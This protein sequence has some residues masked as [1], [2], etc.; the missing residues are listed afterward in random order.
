MVMSSV[1]AAIVT[2]AAEG[3]LPCLR[4]NGDLNAPAPAGRSV[5]AGLIVRLLDA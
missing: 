2:V 3:T 4:L 1:S 5:A